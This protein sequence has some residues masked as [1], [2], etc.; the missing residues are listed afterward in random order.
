MKYLLII[1]NLCCLTITMFLVVD[2]LYGNFETTVY[3]PSLPG[4]EK[5][6]LHKNTGKPT[7]LHKNT[8][9]P[10]D[11]EGSY[12][13]LSH[14]TIIR[15]RNLFNTVVDGTGNENKVEETLSDT[16][17]KSLEKTDLNLTLWGTVKG[18]DTENYA[19]IESGKDHK[20]GLYKQSDT[21]EGTGA[22]IKKVL[23]LSVILDNNGK[24]QILEMSK[25]PVSGKSLASTSPSSRGSADKSSSADTINMT[26]KR[27][28]IDESMKDINTLMKQVRVR[29][30]FTGGEADGILL[31]GIKQKSIFREMGIRNGDIIMGVDGKDIRSVEDAITLYDTLRNASEAKIEIKRRGKKKELL[32]H[33]E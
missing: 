4:V 32:Y 16:E 28:M 5:T 20:Q 22:V 27:S 14:Y 17:I 23:R 7:D 12:L 24:D 10:T 25:E 6:K 18:W 2:T 1:L 31:Y 9:K 19:V 21:I 11:G 33:V 13:P 3:S 29:P 30:H 8:G 15:Q 26:I